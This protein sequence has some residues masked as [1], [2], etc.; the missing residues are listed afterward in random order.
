MTDECEARQVRQ[1]VV[2]AMAIRRID[3]A[4]REDL[5]QIAT[6]R[7]LDFLQRLHAAGTPVGAPRAYCRQVA[8]SVWID[9]LRRRRLEQTQGGP[10]GTTDVQD[11][12]DPS[13]SVEEQVGARRT[14][15]R[16]P[17]LVNEMP[18]SYRRV[19]LALEVRNTSPDALATELGR[20]RNWVDQNRRRARAW[21][22]LRLTRH[23]GEDV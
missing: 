13:P 9:H 14:L 19:F 16:L 2:E 11:W 12:P 3:E 22:K 17:P 8:R 6:M 5:V 7:A 10:A 15:E 18:E 21:L 4:T 20:S 1:W 23:D